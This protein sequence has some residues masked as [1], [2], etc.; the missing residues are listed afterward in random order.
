MKV[1]LMSG[2]HCLLAYK[3]TLEPAWP[4]LP[5]RDT[6][7]VLQDCGRRLGIAISPSSKLVPL[8]DAPHVVPLLDRMSAWPG[9]RP[10]GEV[11]EYQLIA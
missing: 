10:C 9:I 1:A 2:R 7:K 8:H 11:S 3:R 4:P 6:Q 5:S